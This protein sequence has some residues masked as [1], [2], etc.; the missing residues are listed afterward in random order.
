M[1]TFPAR[2]L[3]SSSTTTGCSR[4]PAGPQWRTVAGGSPRYVEALAR[5]VRATASGWARRSRAIDR[6]SPTASPSRPRGGEP[7]R[8]DEVVLGDALRPGAGACSP[9]RATASARCSARSRTSPTRRCCTPTA[10]C[11][12]GAARAWASWNFH[13]LDE[14]TGKTTVTYHMNTLQS[15]RRAREF[16]VTLNRTEAIDPEQVIRD[17]RLRPPRLHAARACA[18]QARH[19]EISGRQPHALLRRLLGLGLPRGRRRQRAARR[20]AL[21]G[22]ADERELRLRGRR[23][24]TAA[25]R[26]ASTSFATAS[27]WSTSTSTSCPG[28]STAAAVVGAPPGA[29]LVPA[30]ATTSATPATPLAEAVR[31]LVAERTGARPDGPIRLLTH[32]RTL[33]H[34]FNPVSFYYCFDARRRAPRA[35]S[36]PR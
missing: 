25:T 20:R 8:F 23:S 13:L 16:C 19:A 11:C 17:D 26:R 22:A 4:S 34:C 29:R 9:T 31:D 35:R 30:R 32:L 7:E 27:R 2:F 28:C 3:L 18:A 1:W 5:A 10:R 14:P 12:R 36:S 6:A 21:R 24:A 33:G 15:L